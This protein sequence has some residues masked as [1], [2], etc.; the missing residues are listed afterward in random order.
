MCTFFIQSDLIRR[1]ILFRCK[2][3]NL[4]TPI[5][6]WHLKWLYVHDTQ[7]VKRD[8]Y[9]QPLSDDAPMMGGEIRWNSLQSCFFF[10][11]FWEVGNEFSP[12]PL[13]SC[14]I[15]RFKGCRGFLLRRTMRQFKNY[16]R[17]VGDSTCHS[18]DPRIWAA[19]VQN[20]VSRAT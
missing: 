17:Q 3:A 14:Q 12:L 5:L 4:H 13:W 2:I 10:L 11:F 8:S 16:I 1:T 18:E 7:L 9:L 6:F 19:A 20:L 15:F